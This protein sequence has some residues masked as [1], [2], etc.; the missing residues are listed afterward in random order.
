MPGTLQVLG[1]CLVH[2]CI[3]DGI[4]FWAQGPGKA[5]GWRHERGQRAQG[6]VRCPVWLEL[7]LRGQ[8]YEASGLRQ[9]LTRI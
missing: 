5:K 3:E 7:R 2:E 4:R 1:K 9:F 8:M 6:K